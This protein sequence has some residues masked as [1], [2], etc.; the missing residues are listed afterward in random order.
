[1]TDTLQLNSST[2]TITKP[3]L[4]V[5]VTELPTQSNDS[6][7]YGFGV[8]GMSWTDSRDFRYYDNPLSADNVNHLESSDSVI[9]LPREALDIGRSFAGLWTTELR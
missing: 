9:F 5:H 8:T 1:M 7:I 2:L 3:T 6:F 4:A